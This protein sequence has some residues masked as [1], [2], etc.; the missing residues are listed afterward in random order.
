MEAKR[1]KIVSADVACS[2]KNVDS[3]ALALEV[4][5]SLLL[6]LKKEG[7]NYIHE[8]NKY[9]CDQGVVLE[10]SCTRLVCT[11]E[12]VVG[13]LATKVQQSEGVMGEKQD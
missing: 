10:K 11:V 4:D 6:S 7:K 13:K 3:A 2:S 5:N 8:L 1:V 9:T 12:K